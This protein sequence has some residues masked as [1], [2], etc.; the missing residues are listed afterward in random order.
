[1]K[2][3]TKVLAV[4]IL[5]A[6]LAII[7]TVLILRDQPQ[8]FVPLPS[9]SPV[10]GPTPSQRSEIRDQKSDNVKT[11]DLAV[12]KAAAT[13]GRVTKKQAVTDCSIPFIAY[14][15]ERI[16]PLCLQIPAG[17]LAIALPRDAN[18]KPVAETGNLQR[19]VIVTGPM[20]PTC[21]G[22][23]SNV[24][25][26]LVLG[27]DWVVINTCLKFNEASRTYSADPSCNFA[28]TRFAIY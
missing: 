18:S 13:K 9:P 7:T 2:A 16:G 22:N 5:I 12:K 15:G 11:V 1:M 25:C 24:P 4:L 27:A 8:E 10:V 21:A 6:I 23:Y 3:Q 20:P 19:D 26:T 14:G 17:L 28:R